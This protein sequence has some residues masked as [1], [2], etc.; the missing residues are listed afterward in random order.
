MG[1]FLGDVMK[2]MLMST[3]IGAIGPVNRAMR[4]ATSSERTAEKHKLLTEEQEQQRQVLAAQARKK[5]AERRYALPDSVRQR[6]GAAQARAGESG[7]RPAS[8]FLG[9]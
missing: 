1:G 8:E 6:A 4:P 2:P 3:G 5:E 7:K 9:S